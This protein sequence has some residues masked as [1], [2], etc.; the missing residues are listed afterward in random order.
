[1]NKSQ[2]KDVRMFGTTEECMNQNQVK[3]MNI[4]AIFFDK[5]QIDSEYCGHQRAGSEKVVLS[6]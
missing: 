1:M 2:T 3:W 6:E 4:L 5:R